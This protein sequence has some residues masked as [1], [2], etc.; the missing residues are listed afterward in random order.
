MRKTMIRASINRIVDDRM[1]DRCKVHANLM[2]ASRLQAYEQLR[3]SL[4][5]LAQ[6]VVRYRGAAV[7][8]NRKTQ[9]IGGIASDR[10][11]DRPFGRARDTADERKILALN[12][13]LLHRAAERR[14]CFGRLGNRDQTARV[15]IET[16]DQAGAHAF[17]RKR[18]RDAQA[19][20]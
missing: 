1:S 13:A 17:T 8:A 11:V 12:V 16:M 9:A 18:R 15:A 6:R 7:R 20:H 10:S 14:Q 19:A 3:C 5:L 2:R 4:E